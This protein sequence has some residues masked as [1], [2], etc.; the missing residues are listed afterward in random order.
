MLYNLL[1]QV[2]IFLVN[3]SSF[4]TSCIVL[5]MQEEGQ[6]NAIP[7]LI[8]IGTSVLLSIGVYQLI[9]KKS[10]MNN[11]YY[12]IELTNRDGVIT[13]SINLANFEFKIRV[14][15]CRYIVISENN[16]TY[17]YLNTYQTRF[18]LGWLTK[19]L[20][21]RLSPFKCSSEVEGIQKL[22]H[23]CSLP[24]I[25]D[26]VKGIED[27]EIVIFTCQELRQKFI[28]QVQPFHSKM[29]ECLDDY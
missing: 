15:E 17:I 19:F 10:P 29:V 20:V 11:S 9:K 25:N 13:D 18:I 12:L 8:G 22:I 6:T 27:K 21:D 4:M 26:I 28:S 5:T 23:K 2:E 3:F 1:E 14:F 16:S 7:I 24:M